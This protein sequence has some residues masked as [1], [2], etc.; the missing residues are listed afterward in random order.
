[1]S[2]AKENAVSVWLKR[3]GMAQFVDCFAEN[4]IDLELLPELTSEDLKELDVHR[5]ADR[6]RLLKEIRLLSV[7]KA[8]GSIQRRLLS[9]F[10]CDMVGSTARS[11]EIDP[12]Q[13][14]G[15][16]KLY[17][18]TVV[19][20]VNRH[21]G[22]VARF[23]G[24]GVLAYFGWPHADED[25]ASQAVRA[26]LD[27]IRSLDKLKSEEEISVHCRVG[28]A[29]GRVVV[30]GQ[31]D[32]D[33]AFGKTPNLAARLQSLAEVDQIVIDSTTYRA[34]GDGFL[35][36]YLQSAQLK[37]FDR[38]QGAW[39][40]LEERRYVERFES[41]RGGRSEFVARDTELNT[42]NQAWERTRSGTGNVV[43]VRGD[44][45][46]GKSRL[47]KYFQE[48]CVPKETE[49]LQFHCSPHHSNSAFYPVI[50]SFAKSAGIL[51]GS[52]SDAE[53]LEKMLGA[54]HPA[55]AKNP[56]SISLLSNFF[57][58]ERVDDSSVASLTPKERRSETIELMVKDVLYRAG[59]S[60][61]LLV[62]EDV[63][64]VDPSTLEVL[65]AII[66]DIHDTPILI[67]VSCR[68][69]ERF[70]LEA[71]IEHT[72]LILERLD[73]ESIG[74][75]VQS[76]DAGGALSPD[77]I[78][79][80]ARRADGVPLFAEEITLAAMELGPD[81]QE[82]ELPES[83]EASLA[84][85][86]DHMGNAKRVL[87][88]ASIIGREFQL[89]QCR[90]LAAT[91]ESGLMDALATAIGSGLLLEDQSRDDRVFRFAHALIQDVAYNGLLKMQRRELHRRF[92]TEVMD[93]AAT[94]KSP[95]L[96]AHHLTRAG[97]TT[98]AID[99]WKEAGSQAAA[100]SANTEA[101]AHFRNGL[102]LIPDLPD[103]EHR[104]ELEFALWVGMAMPLIVETGYTSDEVQQCI[105]SALTVSKRIKYT[106]DIYSLLC[107]QWGFQLTVGMMEESRHTAHQFSKLADRQN[108]E[109][110]KYARYRMLGASHMCQGELQ[111]ARL[112]LSKLVADY[113]PEK[114]ACLSAVYGLNLRVAGACFLSEVLWLLG[115]VE[116]AKQSCA[117]AL[118]EAR[119][120]NHLQSHAISLHFCG[121]VAFL[122]RDRESVREY[123][124]EMLALAEKQSIG[125]WPT[126]A[127]AMLGWANLEEDF[128]GSLEKLKSGVTAAT[129]LGVAMFIP[130]FYCRIAEVL[131]T[132]ARFDE[133]ETYLLAAQKL[134]QRTGEKLFR[135][136]M[137]QLMAQ[138]KLQKNDNDPVE[139]IFNEALTHARGQRAR[140]V[141]LRIATA[142]ARHLL[143]R[144]PEEA[145]NILKPVLEYFDEDVQS[146]D[147]L[148]ARAVLEG[149]LSLSDLDVAT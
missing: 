102:K 127:A 132:R 114:H 51:Q 19:R 54:L 91:T 8:Q 69:T 99:H 125:A 42:L 131:L 28:I 84:A 140:S 7:T 81:G 90:A 37:G 95:E 30:G 143:G 50:Q 89:C 10:F 106:P 35:V 22:F 82:L 73:D 44:P 141:E 24:D 11:N 40:V 6:K 45:G 88:V 94:Q 78:N 48:H 115:F 112:E 33:S 103:S 101:I 87:Q 130:F 149:T 36:Q 32:L 111:Q 98:L 80:I 21:G 100:A 41:R 147:I 135:G 14:R 66:E 1:M 17:Q 128:E 108:D 26:G 109:I 29:T 137:L 83:L 2:D 67:L 122:N 85:R 105:N 93:E 97:E 15:E 92:A 129:E 136:E 104:D 148:K 142:Y 47:L 13:L 139:D 4:G 61:V 116:E 71:S 133:C 64:W 70:K 16:M 144:R 96:I 86:L 120:I 110:A 60:T 18:D 49:I 31:Q 46:I 65:N 12:E 124:S 76:M 25:Q 119:E 146:E 57:S 62:M 118:K 68:P 9:V 63:H 107:S 74:R 55:T 126:L 5:L 53:K 34:I 38:P 117:N 20:A 145:R 138:L 59:R 75:L 23:T 113:E 43:L 77:D 123:T 52:D 79:N 58:I 39:A 72:E 134:M 56:L 27:A 121:L 3:V